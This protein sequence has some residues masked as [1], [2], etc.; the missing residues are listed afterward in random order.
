MH[1]F[2]AVIQDT[3]TEATYSD[4][5]PLK[6]R[7]LLIR[8]KLFVGGFTSNSLAGHE[9]DPKIVAYKIEIWSL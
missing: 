7:L 8:H 4:Y 1:G 9:W 5:G 3:I 6:V 2:R